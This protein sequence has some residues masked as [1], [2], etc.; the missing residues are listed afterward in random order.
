MAGKR[1]CNCWAMIVE[2]SGAPPTPSL[3]PSIFSLTPFTPPLATALGPFLDHQFVNTSII[4]FLGSS[5]LSA[6]PNTSTSSPP[7]DSAT[8]S[9]QHTYSVLNPWRP[10]IYTRETWAMLRGRGEGG[11]SGYTSLGLRRGRGR[12]EDE[13]SGVI[14]VVEERE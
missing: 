8:G 2:K 11:T 10:F 9:G 13:G 12:G 4:S 14:G 5:T 3:T 6:L 1:F 7:R